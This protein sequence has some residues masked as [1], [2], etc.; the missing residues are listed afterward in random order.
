MKADILGVKVDSLTANQALDKVDDFLSSNNQHQIITANPEIVL[1]AWQNREYQQLINRTGLVTADGSGLL[2]AAKF[3]SLKSKGLLISL[4]QLLV[5]VFALILNP[6]YLKEIIPERI[7][8]VDLMEKIC[9]LASK[10]DWKIYLLGGEQRI[11]Q[12]TAEALKK[13]YLNLNIVGAEAGP[14]FQSSILNPQS[15]N[16]SNHKFQNIID[17]IKQQKPNILFVAFGS[18]KQD[19]WINE[20]LSKMPSVKAAMGVGGAFDFISGNVK[21]A[22]EIY[23]DLNI[24]WLF[25][26]F[27]EP[28]RVPRIFNATVKFI[29][30]VVKY[31]HL[32]QI[33]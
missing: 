6:Q 23:R 25:R 3:L 12:K 8:G 26:M 15:L 11:A 33:K 1:A 5:T 27:N 21:R 20:N 22:P 9:E 29:Y 32:V 10:K 2:W 17:N 13:K 14:E 28:W 4:I 7:T 30:S 19:F 24:E 18:P 16:N 31:K